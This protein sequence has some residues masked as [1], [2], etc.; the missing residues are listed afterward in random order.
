MILN[1]IA[2]V[3]ARRRAL[4]A[5]FDVA[6]QLEQLEETCVLSYLHRNP[7]AAAVAWWRL[8]AAAR[9]H[10]R[11]AAPGPVLDF[12]AACGELRHLLPPAVPYDFVEADPEMARVLAE[13]HPTAT[14][15]I[16]AELPADR[17][18]AVFALDSL[19]HNLDVG[20]LLDRLVASLAPGAVLI[21]SGPTENRLYRLGRRLA[22]FTGLS[23]VTTIHHIEAAVAARLNLVHRRNVPLGLPLFSVSTWAR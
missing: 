11:Y 20:T 17:Y 14:R 4:R 5:R 7:A 15:R 21:L 2:H 19:E 9:F 12:G 8:F 3:M 6:R 1:P 23:H 16:L 18:A 22:G 13:L 10:R